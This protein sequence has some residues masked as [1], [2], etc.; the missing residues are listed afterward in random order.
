MRRSATIIVIVLAAL[1]FSHWL[2]ETRMPVRLVEA[3]AAYDLKAWHFLVFISL[4]MLLL[5]TVLEGLSIVLIIVPLVL[6]LL[7]ELGIDPIH[8]A[9]IVVINIEIAMLTPPI[10]LN[11]FVLSGVSKAPLTEV[12]PVFVKHVVR[13]FHAASLISGALISVSG[14]SQTGPAGCQLRVF[15]DQR[16]GFCARA[17]A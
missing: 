12:I 7:L 17:F 13:R 8:F 1:L 10:G 2:T 4:V 16:S 14:L 5:G 15:P 11:L 3:L 9:I 6:P